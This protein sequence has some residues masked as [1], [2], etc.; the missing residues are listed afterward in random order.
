MRI[1]YDVVGFCYA[2]Y[3]EGVSSCLA[4]STPVP[5]QVIADRI[6]PI[7][8]SENNTSPEAII[9]QWE[10]AFQGESTSLMRILPGIYI[11]YRKPVRNG[12]EGKEFRNN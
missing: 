11:S 1:G 9:R 7:R 10:S 8:K 3:F 12:Y 2:S 5:K 4:N 6:S